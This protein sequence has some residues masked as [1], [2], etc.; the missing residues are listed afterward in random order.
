M[1]MSVK[2]LSVCLTA[3]S[4]SLTGC[5]QV[6]YEKCVTPD[7]TEPMID[8]GKKANILLTSK[9]CVQNYLKMKQYADRLKRANEVCK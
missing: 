1:K 8:N 6:V 3:S 7:V 4:I 9:Q 5:G 2:L